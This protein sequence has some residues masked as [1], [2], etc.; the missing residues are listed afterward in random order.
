MVCGKDIKRFYPDIVM[1]LHKSP[2]ASKRLA[3]LILA[4]I[5]NTSEQ[6]SQ[7]DLMPINMLHKETQA[8]EAL[9]RAD[10]LRAITEMS[11]NEVYPWLFGLVKQG[12]HD[13]NPYVR[14]TA[15]TALLKVDDLTEFD[16]GEYTEEVNEIISAGIKDRSRI[17]RAQALLVGSALVK[18]RESLL[19]MMH[20]IFDKLCGGSGSELA[21]YE[22]LAIV[23]TL[24]MQYCERYIAVSVDEQGDFMKAI[25]SA[26]DALHTAMQP[27]QIIILVNL[28]MHLRSKQITISNAEAASDL[29][30]KLIG[31]IALPLKSVL[32]AHHFEKHFALEILATL[33]ALCSGDRTALVTFER[34][35]GSRLFCKANEP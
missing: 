2:H 12:T 19:E 5:Q 16:V 29:R 27:N 30:I 34:S 35:F 22:N 32:G 14:R 15:L 33:L 7:D 24:V 31:S 26:E 3:Y 8:K 23:A 28:I 1:C 18:P 11:V 13:Q 9:R 17:V 21:E 6:E 20:P 25:A 4:Q 10:A